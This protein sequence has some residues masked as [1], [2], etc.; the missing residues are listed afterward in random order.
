M[1]EVLMR[2]IVEK[3]RREKL[4]VSPARATIEHFLWLNSIDRGKLLAVLAQREDPVVMGY[5]AEYF[6]DV[7]AAEQKLLAGLDINQYSEELERAKDLLTLELAG[8]KIWLYEQLPLELWSMSIKSEQAAITDYLY[9]LS[10]NTKNMAAEVK[11]VAING[12]RNSLESCPAEESEVIETSKD[13]AVSPTV[14]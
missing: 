1:L 14:V 4:P 10:C 12:L 6:E 5:L 7:A 11:R 3:E 9:F 13:S 8:A 2:D